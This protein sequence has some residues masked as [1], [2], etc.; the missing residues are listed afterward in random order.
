MSGTRVTAEDIETGESES[1][2]I[3]DD[4]IIICDGSSY[5]DG[6]AAYPSTGTQVITIKKR[7]T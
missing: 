5:V 6:I 4:F 1:R 2:I 7:A 3:T